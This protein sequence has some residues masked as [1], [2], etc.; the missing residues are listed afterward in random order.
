MLSCF[1]PRASGTGAV[2]GSA[3]SLFRA[4]SSP[5]VAGVVLAAALLLLAPSSASADWRTCDSGVF[6]VEAGEVEPAIA[7]AGQEV[8]FRING[9]LDREIAGGKLEVGIDYLGFRVYSSTGDLCDA[10]SCPMAPGKHTLELRQKLPAA[11]PP[12]PY[13]GVFQA[14]AADGGPLLFCVDINF[15]VSLGRS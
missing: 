7:H 5:S 14:T 8:V 3:R 1:Y 11:T 15:H 6:D 2:T 4:A 9:T 10:V 13:L 12:G